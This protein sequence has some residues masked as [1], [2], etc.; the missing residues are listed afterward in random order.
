MAAEPKKAALLGSDDSDGEAAPKK[1]SLFGEDDDGPAEEGEGAVPSALNSLQ[2][3]KKYASTLL[4]RKRE[5]ELRLMRQKFGDAGDDDDDLS[6]DE[7]SDEDGFMLSDKKKIEI[8]NVLQAV[9]AGDTSRLQEERFFYDSESGSSTDGGYVTDPQKKGR[10]TVKSQLWDAL[11]DDEDLSKLEDLARTYED[12][13][14]QGNRMIP[15]A[16]RQKAKEEFLALVREAETGMQ[17]W[18]LKERQPSAEDAATAR[19]LDSKFWQTRQGRALKRDLDRRVQA[20]SKLEQLF[21]NS[22]KDPKEAFL[23]DYFIND[24]WSWTKATEEAEEAKP[25]RRSAKSRG[26]AAGEEEEEEGGPEEP[27]E[28][29]SSTE[30]EEFTNNQEV[31]EHAYEE[32]KYHHQ[33]EGFTEQIAAPQMG[34]SLRRKE[35]ARKKR[36]ELQAEKEAERERTFQEELSRVKMRKKKALQEK[37]ALLK[38]IAGAKKDRFSAD[39]LHKIRHASLEEYDQ[40]MSQVFNDDYYE[41]ADTNFHPEAEDWAEQP[42]LRKLLGTDASWEKRQLVASVFS[43]TPTATEAA[44]SSGGGGGKAPAGPQDSDSDSDGDDAGRRRRRTVSKETLRRQLEEEVQY[45]QKEIDELGYEDVIAGGTVKCRF[46]YRNIDPIRFEGLD[47]TDLLVLPDATLDSIAPMRYLAAHRTKAERDRDRRIVEQR[48]KRLGQVDYK[49]K[50]GSKKY[51][52]AS[53]IDPATWDELQA[54]LDQLKAEKAAKRARLAAEAAEGEEGPAE[55]ED[56]YAADVGEPAP[57]RTKAKAKRPREVVDTDQIAAEAVQQKDKEKERK[58]K[59][60]KPETS[61]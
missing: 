44:S 24:G 60:H 6:T 61:A 12:Q 29:P 19:E 8:S 49:W 33:E 37:S 1:L 22:S 3:D 15:A 16:E 31:F 53:G 57:P 41:E 21:S 17:N 46:K 18:S 51:K 45:T 52:K 23:K 27:P 10:Y 35:S 5:Q 56:G 55:A 13:D 28:A 58:Q 43:E 30:D 14:R 4:R 9:R 11:G 26:E 2:V 34:P 7:T 39:L 59:K 20:R 36:R 38:E 47:T 25:K 50:V 54:K 42:E 40:L 32:F 48:L